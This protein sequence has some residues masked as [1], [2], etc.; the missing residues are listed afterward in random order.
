MTILLMQV[1]ETPIWLLSK[2]RQDDARKSLQWLR[3]WVP[4]KAVDREYDELQRY[5]ETSRACLECE[6]AAVKCP[7][8]PPTLMEKIRDLLRL[9]TLKPFCIIMTMFFV[10]QFSGMFAMRPYIM[11]ILDTYGVPFSPSQTTVVLGMLG[12][13]A[14]IMLLGIVRMVGK[15]NIYL[16]S[17]GGTFVTCFALSKWRR[18]FWGGDAMN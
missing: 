11:Q 1:P 7:H 10:L 14:C 15:R 4:A 5:E 6:K 3:G 13:C 16:F 9:K 18:A 12:I 17:I 2:S 8:P